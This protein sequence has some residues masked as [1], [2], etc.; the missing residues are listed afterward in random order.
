MLLENLSDED[1]QIIDIIKERKSIVLLNKTD[2]PN[3]YDEDYFKKL[4]T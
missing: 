4:I 1:Y 3:K 2:L